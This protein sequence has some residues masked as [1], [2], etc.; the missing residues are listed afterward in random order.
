[1]VKKAAA[2]LLIA[3]SAAAV[4]HAETCR[5]PLNEPRR[6]SSSFGEYRE[7]HYHAG[8]DLRTFGRIGLACLAP[9]SCTAVRL[10]VSPV[11]YGKAVYVRLKDGRMAV[12][13]HLNGFSRELDSLSYYWRL[14]HGRNSCD[15]E[16]SPGV[17]RFAPGETVAFTGS[18]GSPFPHLHFEMRDS[19]GRPFNPLVSMYEVPDACAP[20]LSALEVVPLSWGS[21]VNGS[22]IAFTSR[23]RLA[24]DEHYTLVDTLRLDGLFGFGV[25]AYDKQM[26]GSYRMAPYSVELAIDGKTAYRMRNDRFDYAQVGDIPLEYEDRGGAAPGRYFLL[27][28]KPANTMPDREGT[29]IIASGAGRAGALVLSSGL[30]TGEIVLRDARGN[31]ARGLFRFIVHRYPIVEVSQSGESGA[32]RIEIDSSGPE[33]GSAVSTALSASMDGGRSW[34]AVST[35]HGSLTLAGTANDAP[36][37]L[38]RCVARDSEGARVERFFAFPRRRGGAD[39]VLCDVAAELRAEGLYLKIRT[40]S[41]LASAPSVRGGRSGDSLGVVQ[42]GMRDFI[43]FASVDSLVCGVNIFSIRGTDYR[44]Y[45]LER[46][47]AFSIYTFG[48][49]AP[50]S[51]DASGG[52]AIRLRASSVRGTAAV[53]VRHAGDGG[54][55]SS[56]LTPL[57]A[58]FVLDFPLEAFARPL[59][60]GFDAGR[61][62]GLF[63][64]DGR[65]GWQCVGVPARDGGMVDVRRSG[66]YAVFADTT[67][68]VVKRPGFT[69][70]G[71]G[72]G[73][74][75]ARLCYVPVH[76]RGS[77]IDAD[78]TT[79][80]LNGK[81]VVCEYDEYRGRLAIPVLRSFPRG[82]AKLRIE[83]MD[84][85]GNRSAAEFSIVIE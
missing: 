32:P 38:Y 12:Y 19:A 43:A 76:E 31:E 6:L 40:A 83:I 14:S 84:L 81:R 68:P 39:S 63:R 9:D 7:G 57:G 54:K 5:W 75:K 45:P 77:G 52:L 8:I 58:P 62:A 23:F 22:P 16:L 34:R 78:A 29:G 60:C 80:F 44:G 18:T 85:A 41:A 56:E 4:A 49:G 20:I 61:A 26:L 70:R 73:F 64:W 17:V 42:T 25:K 15:I 10:R 28:R 67:A 74:F 47:R 27:F 65:A 24:H 36:A 50:A 69:R 37:I 21:L 3:L 33:G 66:T 72:S 48:T 59:Q 1:M 51:F 11:G 13:G 79:A 71:P 35:A 53:M 82:P 30:H 2:M 55:H 46:V